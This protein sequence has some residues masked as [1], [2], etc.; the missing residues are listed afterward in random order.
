MIFQKDGKSLCL[1]Q[2][3]VNDPEREAFCQVWQFY[4]VSRASDTSEHVYCAGGAEEP[5]L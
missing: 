4:S 1:P 2:K 3:Y 5:T